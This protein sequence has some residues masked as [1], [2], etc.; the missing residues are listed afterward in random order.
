[1]PQYFSCNP[2]QP[3]T[4]AGK[5]DPT[6][7][8][9]GPNPCPSLLATTLASFLAAL[10]SAVGGRIS[11]CTCRPIFANPGV[12]S[13][14]KWHEFRD[15]V[16]FRTVQFMYCEQ[17][18]RVHSRSWAVNR[19]RELTRSPRDRGYSLECDVYGHLHDAL[20]WLHLTSI[21]CR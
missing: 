15:G 16:Q 1:M 5:C 2:T 13:R 17:T 11:R 7:P 3:I 8:M 6:Q 9:D 21:S 18:F 14:I 12:N 10:V 20:P 4:C 19:G